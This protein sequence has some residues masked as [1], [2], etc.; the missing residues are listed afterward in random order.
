MERL[1]AIMLNTFF[2]VVT[3]R[4]WNVMMIDAALSP[5]GF[6]I[7]IKF[8]ASAVYLRHRSHLCSHLLFDV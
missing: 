7:S 6:K 3:S 4:R 5:V 2:S 8:T 1:A